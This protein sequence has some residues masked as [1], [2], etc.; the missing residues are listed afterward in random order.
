MRHVLSATLVALALGG[1]AS[2]TPIAPS[3]FGPLAQF[4]SFEEAMPGAN[5]ALGLGASLLEPGAIDVYQFATGVWLTSPIPNPGYDAGGAFVHDFALGSDVQNNWGAGRVVND[6]GDVPFGTAYL[7]AY[8]PGAGTASI[9]LTFSAAM[10][11]VGAYVTGARNTT[12]RIDVY[13]RNGVLLESGSVG[14]VDLGSWDVSF[15]GRENLAGIKRVVFSGRDFG[16]D[17]LTYEPHPVSV[18]EPGTLQTVSFG[19]IGLIGLAALGRG[20]AF[21]TKRS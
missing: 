7:G 21:A 10:D 20:K 19:L 13:D 1:S 3:A 17:G 4:E 11:R 8:D 5:V 14:T 16:I 15:L 18:P 9:E 6:A 2:A 12:V